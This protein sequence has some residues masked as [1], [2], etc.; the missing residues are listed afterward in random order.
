MGTYR[1]AEKLKSKKIARAP[2]E[3]LNK[4]LNQ[5]LTLYNSPADFPSF[6]NFRSA[7]EG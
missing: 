1:M 3:T 6:K 4:S 7:K 2:K 5:E